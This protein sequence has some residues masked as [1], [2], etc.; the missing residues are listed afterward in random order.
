MWNKLTYV[1][2]VY[3]IIPYTTHTHQSFTGSFYHFNILKKTNFHGSWS[4]NGGEQ[5]MQAKLH[6]EKKWE[7]ANRFNDSNICHECLSAR[8]PLDY[9]NYMFKNL[10]C[11]G[12]LLKSSTFSSG[13][14]K[15]NR[16]ILFF[17]SFLGCQESQNDVF[18]KNWMQF[19]C[20]FFECAI[21]L[22]DFTFNT[23]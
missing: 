9:F 12:I 15:C 10:M 17:H 7:N 18:R 14:L 1:Y 22:R 8:V 13:F 23:I 11:M 19:V 3:N 6:T 5:T 16:K 20:W 4:L 21:F 2:I